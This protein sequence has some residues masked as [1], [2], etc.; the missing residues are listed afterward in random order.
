MA[1]VAVRA[2]RADASRSPIKSRER[3]LSACDEGQRQYTKTTIIAG[4]D[5]TP[6]PHFLHSCTIFRHNTT[7]VPLHTPHFIIIA[8]HLQLPTMLK[9]FPSSHDIVSSPY[10]KSPARL[11]NLHFLPRTV[12]VSVMHRSYHVHALI[13]VEV[14]RLRDE[15][16]RADHSSARNKFGLLRA[17]ELPRFRARYLGRRA[18]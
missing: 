10:T 16:L 1:W 15:S 8:R 2:E 12:Q 9:L 14:E 17:A 7:Y 4:L 13:M 6:S 11:Q 5:N 3:E 18:P